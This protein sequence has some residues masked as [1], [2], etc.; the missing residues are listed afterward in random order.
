LP[1]YNRARFL[2]QAIQSI[3]DQQGSDWELI[4]VDDGSTDETSELIVQLTADIE[5]PVRYIRQENQGAYAARN[6][7]LDHASGNYIAFF[8][9]D[10]I[11]LPHHLKDCVEA[12]AANP[13][14]HWVYGACRV[15]DEQTGRVLTDSTFYVNGE[16]R[17]FLKL[18][19]R[20]SGQLQI[21]EDRDAVRCMILYGLYSGLQNS[22]IRRSVFDTDRF[23]SV[24]RNE[25]EDQLAVIRSLTRGDRFAFLHNVHVIYT[26]HSG[27]SSASAH[28]GCFDR[29]LAVQRVL[30]ARLERLQY[31]VP[32]TPRERRALRQRLSREHF[33]LL[34]YALQWSNGRRNEA[35]ASF[36]R[37]ISYAPWNLGYWKTYLGALARTRLGSKTLHV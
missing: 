18:K 33:W 20:F 35:L 4:I 26:I 27:N 12:L 5:Q 10:D 6:T 7:G 3:R 34:G 24:S 31:E 17:P 13:D 25:A 15:V 11:W 37:G 19:H 14:V 29:K 16:P 23:E 9:S 28:N 32:L 2:P 1:T 36:R 22:V 30:L 21:I 8:D